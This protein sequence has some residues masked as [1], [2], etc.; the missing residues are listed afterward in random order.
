MLI[1]TMNV[2][3]FG[4]KTC[5]VFATSCWNAQPGRSGQRFSSILIIRKRRSL[6]YMSIPINSTLTIFYTCSI[7]ICFNTFKIRKMSKISSMGGKR[8]SISSLKSNIVPPAYPSYLATWLC[9]L[10]KIQWQ[11]AFAEER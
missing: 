2:Q 1:Y 8:A 9:T 5:Q 7:T 6:Q 3:D 10:G 11:C 4:F